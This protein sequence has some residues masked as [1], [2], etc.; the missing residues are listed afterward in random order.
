MARYVYERYPR[1]FSA[2]ITVWKNMTFGAPTKSV[3]HEV[4]SKWMYM[5]DGSK[6]SEK[7][8]Q[9][10]FGTSRHLDLAKFQCSRTE[11]DSKTHCYSNYHFISVS[12][13]AWLT[14]W[15]NFSL[16][17]LISRYIRHIEALFPVLSVQFWHF[18]VA[19]GYLKQTYWL[20]CRSLSLALYIANEPNM[21][22]FRNIK[23]QY[24]NKQQGKLGW[25]Q[26]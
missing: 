13:E 22:K 12:K 26:F 4:S 24:S 11:R 10:P 1:P 7:Y 6:V 17:S 8:F 14:T 16:S 9:L 15:L 25:V 19:F 3:S 20:F 21:I 5:Y 2:S 18:S 23:L